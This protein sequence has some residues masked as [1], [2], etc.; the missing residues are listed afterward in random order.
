MAPLNKPFSHTFLSS[1]QVCA[2]G[3]QRRYVNLLGTLPG[4]Q[5]WNP[6]RNAPAEAFVF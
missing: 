2:Y 1:A 5:A 3:G 6:S 4:S